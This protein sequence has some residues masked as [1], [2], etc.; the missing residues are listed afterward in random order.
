[1][2][3]PGTIR[4][5]QT[6]IDPRTCRGVQRDPRDVICVERVRGRGTLT[7]QAIAEPEKFSFQVALVEWEPHPELETGGFWKPKT[8]TMKVPELRATL[9]PVARV[10][11]K[12]QG[13][14]AT[15][16]A[17]DE[18]LSRFVDRTWN[19]RVVYLNARTGEVT[20]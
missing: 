1:M 4:K 8:K 12:R 15:R 18:L 11:L 19:S 2:S 16:A 3:T 17:L 10:Q 5:P 14:P 6:P 20:T 13:R 9:E 7:L